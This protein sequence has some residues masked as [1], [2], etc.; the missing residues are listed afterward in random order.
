MNEYHIIVEAN[1]IKSFH[2]GVNLFRNFM[3]MLAYPL[4]KAS[5]KIH[6]QGS[7]SCWWVNDAIPTL[8]LFVFLPALHSDTIIVNQGIVPEWLILIY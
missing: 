4:A 1:S 6:L 3:F 5:R 2:R 7:Q 8:F